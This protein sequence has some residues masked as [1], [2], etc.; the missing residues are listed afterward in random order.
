MSRNAGDTLVIG[1]RCSTCT[2]MN[3]LTRTQC[4]AC[5]SKQPSN[6]VLEDYFVS[7]QEYN[8]LKTQGDRSQ[9]QVEK[10]RL[11]FYFW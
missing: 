9:K 3:P 2:L 6:V 11:K 5:D 1:W 10:V 4:D 7:E 8:Q